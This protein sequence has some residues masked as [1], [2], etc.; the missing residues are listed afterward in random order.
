[1]SRTIDLTG[2][3]FGRL[4]V[5]RRSEKARSSGAL[6]DC[7]CVCGGAACVDSRKLR[8]G[9]STS[10]G[11][12]RRE[13]LSNLRHGQSKSSPTYRSWKEMRS[14]CNNP[15]AQNFKWYGGRG[16]RVC[17]EWG[18]YEAFLADMGERPAGKTLDRID[19]DGNYEKQNCRW[20]TAKEQAETNRGC[21][22]PGEN[23][24]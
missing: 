9:H 17:P 18:S 16:I 20:A 15:K 3:T 10:C 12:H 14:R 8:T 5:I 7:S 13:V 24:K 23:R 2:Q 6:W 1:M 11:C 21:F 4:T 22:K 19:S